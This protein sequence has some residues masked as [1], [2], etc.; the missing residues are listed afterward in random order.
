MSNIERDDLAE[1]V[2]AKLRITALRHLLELLDML[3][4]EQIAREPMAIQTREVDEPVV[5]DDILEFLGELKLEATDKLEQLVRVLVLIAS[6]KRE[7][8]D[9]RGTVSF[10]LSIERIELTL[11]TSMTRP[12]S[13]SA[14]AVWKL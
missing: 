12:I 4:Y 9:L 7:L 5:E 1:E 3:L 10:G 8:P 13:P 2:A 6:S 11:M 14:T